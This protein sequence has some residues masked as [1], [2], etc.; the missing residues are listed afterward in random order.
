LVYRPWRTKAPCGASERMFF[1]K[2]YPASTAPASSLKCRDALLIRAPPFYDVRARML[3]LSRPRQRSPATLFWIHGHP[4]AF[5]S[6]AMSQLSEARQLSKE[7]RERREDQTY[8][9]FPSRKTS[10]AM[11]AIPCE[12]LSLMSASDAIYWT[13]V[14]RGV[15]I[16]EPDEP[17][18]T[19]RA[20]K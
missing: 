5:C 14:A 13:R 7:S 1:R 18:F 3:W 10:A 12:R 9:L 8:I 2:P 6:T 15:V 19:G 11:A 16:A 4:G 20:A 17:W